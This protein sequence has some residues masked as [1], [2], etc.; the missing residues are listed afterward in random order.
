MKLR[1]SPTSPYV[2]KV[3]VMAIETRMDEVIDLAP[4]DPHDP[5]TNLG[6][7]NPL[8]KV[9]TLVTDDGFVVF[10]S[11]LICEYLDSAHGGARLVPVATPARWHVL[12][13]QS[14][15]DGIMDAA[16]GIVMEGRRPEDERSPSFV[17]KEENRIGRAI[18]WLEENFDEIEG[19]FNLG[20]I[21]VACAL[22]YLDFRLPHLTWRDNA[23]K[24]ASWFAEVNQRESMRK[25]AP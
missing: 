13:L 25:T 21:S 23:T 4:T 14:L 2:R 7:V 6:D 24:L 19:G 15:G 1:Y 22:G 16:V 12:R 9:P 3:R 18:T 5:A 8:G 17:A 20:Q 11:P 10:D